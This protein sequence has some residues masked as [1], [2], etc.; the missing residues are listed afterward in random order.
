MQYD[1]TIPVLEEEDNEHVQKIERTMSSMSLSSSR[2][3][4]VNDT[5]PI[6]DAINEKKEFIKTLEAATFQLMQSPDKAWKAKPHQQQMDFFVK[7]WGMFR[8][9]ESEDLQRIAMISK[10]QN[11]E[12]TKG[13]YDYQLFVESSNHLLLQKPSMRFPPREKLDRSLKVYDDNNA[14][15]CSFMADM[16]VT[17][18]HMNEWYITD[19]HLFLK[20]SR[21]L[22]KLISY[23]HPSPFVLFKYIKSK[24]F[25]LEV[26]IC[27][28]FTI[29]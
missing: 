25:K 13:I 29:N 12:T 7:R 28:I 11:D 17:E 20:Y 21:Y 23:N 6:G 5:V 16:D 18:S 8:K 15:R 3:N 9:R 1:P 10:I 14:T 24:D 22:W 2:D 26:F 19:R 27:S 4:D